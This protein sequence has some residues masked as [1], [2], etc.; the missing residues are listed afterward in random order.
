MRFILRLPLMLQR[1]LQEGAGG[2]EKYEHFI[3]ALEDELIG[4]TAMAPLAASEYR[5]RAAGPRKAWERVNQTK[6]AHMREPSSAVARAW[7]LVSNSLA[8]CARTDS[9]AKARRARWKLMHDEHEPPKVGQN[10]P[11]LAPWGPETVSIN[12]C[13]QK[14]PWSII[15]IEI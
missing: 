8:D 14:A 2:D 1:E 9:R 3:G 12:L 7:K 5:G 6:P 10:W 11:L 4:L 15:L 13:S